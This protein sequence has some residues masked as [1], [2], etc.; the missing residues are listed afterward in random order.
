MDLSK[1]TIRSMRDGEQKEL[2]RIGRR[3]FWFVEALT[4]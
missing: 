1:V 3:A 4:G 2:Q